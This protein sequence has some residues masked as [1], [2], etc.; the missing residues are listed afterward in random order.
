MTYSKLFRFALI[1]F[2]FR[3]VA[4]LAARCVL[5]ADNVDDLITPKPIQYTGYHEQLD[6]PLLSP[7]EG[8]RVREFV[9]ANRQS[10]SKQ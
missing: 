3:R 10:K 5:G 1:E 4:C 2:K 7:M 8:V 9:I 6:K